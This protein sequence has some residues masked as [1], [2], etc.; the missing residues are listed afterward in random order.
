MNNR[1]NFFK[2]AGLFGAA[3]VAPSAAIAVS[4]FSPKES[5]E[6][7]EPESSSPAIVMKGKPQVNRVS[8]GTVEGPNNIFSQNEVDNNAL[9][10]NDTFDD[11]A[12]CDE[13]AI[14]IGKDKR[15]W[16]QVE[17][18]WKRVVTEG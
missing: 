16:I 15:L 1:R 13:V 9:L 18:K 17:G 8:Y 6:H 10:F 7:L 2:R 14:S 3:A 4:A 11:E 12:P 5:I